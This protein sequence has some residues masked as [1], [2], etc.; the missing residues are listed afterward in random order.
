MPRPRKPDYLKA[1]PM[2]EGYSV[3]SNKFIWY[4]IPEAQQML[5]ALCAKT[6]LSRSRQICECIFYMTL[7]LLPE[8]V[9]ALPHVDNRNRLER[10]SRLDK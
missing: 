9:V 7:H 3:Q 1:R 4:M 10:R 6:G 2:P 8:A 5:N